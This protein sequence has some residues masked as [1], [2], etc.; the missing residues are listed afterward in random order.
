MLIPQKLFSDGKCGLN[1]SQQSVPLETLNFFKSEDGNTYLLGQHFNKNPKDKNGN[2]VKDFE[3]VKN[4]AQEFNMYIPGEKEDTEVLGIR[5][6]PHV[7][8]LNMYKKT[9]IAVGIAG[10]H[11]WYMLACFPEKPQI[12]FYNKNG[13]ENWDEI[14]KTY[15]KLGHSVYALGFDEHTDWKRFSLEAKAL[16]TKISKKIRQEKNRSTKSSLLSVEHK[17]ALVR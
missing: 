17:N 5:G 4:L 3:H 6:V 10:T 2:E 8:Y 16:Y 7:K 11:T 14:A 12:I 9:D 15:Q 13:V 1:A